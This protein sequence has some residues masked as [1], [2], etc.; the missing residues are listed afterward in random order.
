MLAYRL[1]VDTER[2]PLSP[3]SPVSPISPTSP[4]APSYL[5]PDSWQRDE[6]GQ[7]Q[8]IELADQLIARGAS[9]LEYLRN[10]KR[11]GWEDE[12]MDTYFANQRFIADNAGPELNITW[13][14]RMKKVFGEIDRSALV[15]MFGSFTF[16][17]LGCCPGGFSSY[18]LKKNPQAS[19]IGISLPVEQ[20]GHQFS[21]EQEFLN[22]FTLY[23]A[24]LTRYSFSSSIPTDRSDIYVPIENHLGR[25]KFD[26]ILLD[27]HHLRTNTN[28]LDWE[29]HQLLVSQL[30]IALEYV[31]LGGKL[32]I[33]LSRIER[34]NTVKII[35][36]FDLI[37][38][39]IEAVKPMTMHAKR[40]S[41][42][43]VVHGVGWG[44]EGHRKEEFAEK[45]KEVWTELVFGGDERQGRY[46]T[47][48]DLDFVVTTEDLIERSPDFL[49]KIV[50]IGRGVWQGQIKGLEGLF[51]KNNVG[52]RGWGRSGDG[53]RRS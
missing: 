40:G 22:R 14:R 21:L 27:G 2:E 16:L 52:H 25:S 7:N 13:F 3:I 44:T 10:L 6:R 43:L 20:G 28:T 51:R 32:V 23:F 47:L 45:L 9:E 38:E 31:R 39:R 12:G 34:V 36:L 30:I 1:G 15:P 11:K 53:L 37:S 19:G 26:L 18:I 8:T 24:D 17:D 33:K 42:Y 48:E 35:R 29:I 46:L 49:D 50:E 41:F 4:I 5:F